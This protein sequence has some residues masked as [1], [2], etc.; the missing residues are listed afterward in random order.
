MRIVW[1][2]TFKAIAGI[3][4]FISCANIGRP[5]SGFAWET[6]ENC[7]QYWRNG[8]R[9]FNEVGVAIRF[10]FFHSE[11]FL[12][13]LRFLSQPPC[14]WSFCFWENEI[15]RRPVLSPRAIKSGHL[16]SR[17]NSSRLSKNQKCDPRSSLCKYLS[18]YLFVSKAGLIVISVSVCTFCRLI[19]SKQTIIDER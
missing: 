10:F 15:P 1:D 7:D 16:L 6:A 13:R 14:S 4:V 17:T 11:I 9:W 2:Y 5:A 18:K 8:G 19:A 12:T 3:A